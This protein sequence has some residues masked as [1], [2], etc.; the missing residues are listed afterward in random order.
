MLVLSSGA[1]VGSV[2]GVTEGVALG[3]TVV[4][5]GVLGAVDT[6]GVG[7]V[8]LMTTLLYVTIA[9]LIL[10][11]PLKPTTAVPDDFALNVTV[12]SSATPVCDEFREALKPIVPLPCVSVGGSNLLVPVSEVFLLT[13]SSLSAG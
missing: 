8:I 9:L 3:V 1:A 11:S 12:K 7:L 2:L 4:G 6:I 5:F 10:L 13:T